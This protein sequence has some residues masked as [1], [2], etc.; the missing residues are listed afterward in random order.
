MKRHPGILLALI[1]LFAGTL[2]AAATADFE[3][4]GQIA[5]GKAIQISGVNGNITAEATESGRVEV[6][7][8]KSGKDAD[9]VR[10]EANN[11]EAG[12]VV[13]A[14]YPKSTK[15][16]FQASVQFQVRVPSRVRFVAQT[17]NGDIN[18]TALDS[19]VEA[20]TVNGTVHVSTS[21]RAEAKTVNGAVFARIGN[22]GLQ[23]PLALESVNGRITVDAP[24][25]LNAKVEASTV[26]G[27]IKTG[28]PMAVKGKWG[29]HSMSGDV[30]SGGPTLAMRTVNGHIELRH[31]E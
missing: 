5:P 29:M 2:N 22:G 16:D 21:Q 14:V 15:G 6:T 28:L 8:I 13:K 19:E 27:G 1:T 9:K 12:V 20:A 18:A 26:H 3:W 25:G 23:H 7:A 4:S 31:A 11:N 24:K 30:G 10:V 17:V